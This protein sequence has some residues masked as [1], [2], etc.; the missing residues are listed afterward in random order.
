MFTDRN[1]FV[2]APKQFWED[3]SID[4]VTQGNKMITEKTI[5]NDSQ[6]VKITRDNKKRTFTFARGFKNQIEAHNIETWGF[7][8]VKTWNDA[9]EKAN[10][11]LVIYA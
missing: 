10:D 9:I 3:T 6:W 4:N 2:D 5:R 8:W 11:K 7:E 1:I